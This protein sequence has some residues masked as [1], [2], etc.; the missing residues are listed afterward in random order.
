MAGG[1]AEESWMVVPWTLVAAMGLALLA[2]GVSL[3]IWGDILV[4]IIAVILGLLAILLGIGVL[5]SGHL[6]GKRGFPSL[7]LLFAGLFLVAVG[8]LVLF[9][10]E[11][12]FDLL[13]Y[14]GALVAGIAGLAL[15]F[16]GGLLSVGGWARRFILLGGA[17]L[18]V[19]GVALVLFPGLV[20]RLLVTAAGV[21]TALAGCIALWFALAM[22]R[23]ATLP[24]Q[25]RITGTT[26][27]ANG[28]R[29]ER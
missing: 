25:E 5:S 9:R 8:L 3:V 15:L 27:D 13:I 24:V 10:R 14:S 23:E 12:I 19:A 1:M 7:F 28:R 18:L 17:A 26:G 22:R 16:L 2:V 20:A 21:V 29:Y 4:N 6:M 11:I